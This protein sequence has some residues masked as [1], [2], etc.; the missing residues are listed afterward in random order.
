M[1]TAGDICG[2]P[3]T[4]DAVLET[5]VVGMRHV[6]KGSIQVQG[7][8]E[9]AVACPS[10]FTLQRER[11]NRVDGNAIL[12]TNMQMIGVGLSEGLGNAF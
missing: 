1:P 4:P 9:G 3:A 10:R 5:G 7:G 12:V 11:E 2:A 8:E 6:R